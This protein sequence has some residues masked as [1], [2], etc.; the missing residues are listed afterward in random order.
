V[1]FCLIWFV[2]ALLIFSMISGKQP[3]YV[4]PEFPAAALLIAHVLTRRP[5]AGRPWLPAAVLVLVGVGLTAIGF[6]AALQARFNW[7]SVIPGWAGLPFV[8]AG[9]ML[10]GRANAAGPTPQRMVWAMLLGMLGFFV[11]IVEP[12]GHR[13]DTHVIGQAL[14]RYQ[15]LGR[16]IA[17]QGKYHAQYHFS[18]R[19]VQP[20]DDMIAQEIPDWLE[21]HP[22]GIAVV[23]IEGPR[24]L[25][26]YRP[27]EVQPFRSRR[28]ALVD[29]QAI[30]ALREM[31][32]K[33]PP[34]E[35]AE[36]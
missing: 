22:D 18:G 17:H 33:A 24:D 29:R 10:L 3:H 2:T 1:R 25:A 7:P 26:A 35:N 14:A 31:P 19:L 30:A 32:L 34:A 9:L 23:Y 5:P 21:E 11:G 4:L 16:P 15:A 28:V 12:L 6:S 27:L 13:Y 20:L 8:L 36:D